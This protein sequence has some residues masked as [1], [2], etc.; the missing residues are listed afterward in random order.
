MAGLED[1]FNM[2][3]ILFDIVLPIVL[4]IGAFAIQEIR[5][6]G[7]R[8][9]F[10]AVFGKAT[11]EHENILVIVPLWRVKDASRDEVRFV[12]EL[13]DGSEEKYFGPDDL[14]AFDDLESTSM[15][16]SIFEEFYSKPFEYLMDNDESLNVDDKCIIMLGGPNTNSRVKT[17]L[18][19]TKKD[20]FE[21][22]YESN[23]FGITDV[24][25]D[26]YYD[27]TG[28]WEYGVILRLP[29]GKKGYYFI[30]AGL[31]SIGT[32]AA[33]KYFKNHWE[34]LKKAKPDMGILLRMPRGDPSSYVMVKEYGLK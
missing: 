28:E 30:L 25:D 12:R 24:R 34:D 18:D 13:L 20:L 26:K 9:K 29:N 1:I 16:T 8:K 19:K 10:E 6:R 33:A 23:E 15:T 2:E 21:F 4:F 14:M 22:K 17:I 11:K 7:R 31:S 32:H 5:Q 27:C 3:M